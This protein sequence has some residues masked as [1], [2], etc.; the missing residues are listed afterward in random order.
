MSDRG[1]TESASRDGR[2]TALWVGAVFLAAAATAV[3]VLSDDSRLL[4]LGLVAAL[5]AAL[6]AAFAVARLRGRAAED[7]ER[8]AEQQRIYELELERE[9]AAR[10]EFELEAEAEAR[11]RVAEE[12]DSEIQ[13]LKT[14]LRNLRESLEQMLGGDV[15][16]ERVALRAESTRVRSL[17]ENGATG[18][19]ST[20]IQ[21]SWGRELTS[22]PGGHVNGRLTGGVITQAG[23]TAGP[24]A[25]AGSVPP[26]TV[27]GTVSAN[28]PGTP[29]SA[30]SAAAGGAAP[31]QGAAP[32]NGAGTTPAGGKR[33]GAGGGSTPV[34]DPIPAAGGASGQSGGAQNT[35]LISRLGG[36]PPRDEQRRRPSRPPR[37]KPQPARNETHAAHP[38]PARREKPQYERPDPAGAR[39][40]QQARS[41]REAPA[42]E[43]T[44]KVQAPKAAEEPSPQVD[45]GAHAEGTSVDEL[46]AAYGGSGGT[47][48][49]RRRKE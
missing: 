15:L 40:G 14:E 28:G 8:A 3:L 49:R 35:E 41:G 18:A 5:W 19:Q 23:G 27:N 13:A 42:A 33:G 11:R 9:V 29:N 25:P 7:A 44:R 6:I 1:S 20:S 47:K 10:R 2:A 34:T 30:G 22:G 38:A 16:F 39:S 43:S 31:V 32:G 37:P 45:A 12:S 4:K 48:R 21:Q 17:T 26:T 36:E 24:A 46:L